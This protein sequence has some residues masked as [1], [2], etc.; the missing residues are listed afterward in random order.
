MSA[1]RSRV[2]SRVCEIGGELGFGQGDFVVGGADG[3]RDFFAIAASGCMP[4]PSERQR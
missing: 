4:V 1:D 3:G 2:G